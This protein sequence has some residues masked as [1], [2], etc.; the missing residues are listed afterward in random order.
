MEKLQ[1]LRSLLENLSEDTGL[2]LTAAEDSIY[3]PKCFVP[4][5]LNIIPG[6]GK[7]ESVK[8]AFIRTIREGMEMGDGDPVFKERGPGVVRVV[9][10]LATLLKLFPGDVEVHNIVDQLLKAVERLY[11]EAGDAVSL[12][13]YLFSHKFQLFTI[14][15][16]TA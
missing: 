6:T 9:V 8:D 10:A 1:Y 15:W 7:R 2:P 11:V 12:G 13:N 4:K 14:L 5:S 3:T 16:A